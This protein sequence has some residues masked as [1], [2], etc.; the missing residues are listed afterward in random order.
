VNA[1]AVALDQRLFQLETLYEIGRECASVRSAPEVLEVILSMLMGAFGATRGLAFIG[2]HH[3]QVEAI[4][5]RGDPSWTGASIDRYLRGNAGLDAAGLEVWAPLRVDELTH[6]A[7]ALGPK[8]SGA[9]YSSADQ[10]LF[11]A[12]VANAHTYL[13][14]VKLVDDLARKVRALGVVNEIAVG[15]ATHPTTRRLHRFLLERLASAVHADRAMLGLCG[16]DGQLALAACHPADGTG[17][18]ADGVKQHEMVVPIRF[19]PDAIGTLSLTRGSAFSAEERALVELLANQCAVILENSRLFESFLAQQQEHFR[20][21]GM[22]EQYLAPSVAERLIRGETSPTLEG[23]RVPV[24]VLM[25]DI[26]GSTRL[27]NQVEPEFMVHLLNDYLGRMTDILF[28]YEGTVDK[29]QGDALLG[30]F[31]APEA[32]SDDAVRAVRAAVQMQSAF[33]E[34]T[35]AWT[36]RHPACASLGIGVGVTSGEVVL[37]NIGSTRRIEH[38]VIGPPVNL[39]ARLTA[40]AP[41]GTVHL[42]A[43][44]WAAA[45]QALALRSQRPRHIRAKGFS[46]LVPV[47]RLRVGC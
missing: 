41:A 20:L 42:D 19:G 11:E 3:G 34:L 39:A 31:G 45:A 1:S 13:H 27:I 26:R 16:A 33:A 32:H 24:S 47:Y 35:R 6:G 23:R 21:R 22:L 8:L 36:P 38:T 18:A 46:E 37:G 44:T 17:L 14:N 15:M 29:F 2:D 40:R 43:C 5:E 9:A 7:A 25:V 28:S 30:F 12:I 10:Q 4:C